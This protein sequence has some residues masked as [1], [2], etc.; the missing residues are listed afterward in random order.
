MGVDVIGLLFVI[1][2]WLLFT[3]LLQFVPSLIFTLNV[4]LSSLVV[5]PEFM[6]VRFAKLFCIAPFLYHLVSLFC[7]ES[8][9]SSSLKV[10]AP[11]SVAMAR[12]T[13]NG[14][15]DRAF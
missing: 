5:F 1:V 15:S 6:L 14:G 11:V 8:V 10:Q 4:Q 7:S 2:I 13:P 3:K 9:E 12:S